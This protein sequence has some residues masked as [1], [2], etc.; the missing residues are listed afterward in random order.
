MSVSRNSNNN[1]GEQGRV[2]FALSSR[3]AGAFVI[4]LILL[5]SGGFVLVSSTPMTSA[6]AQEGNDTSQS[7]T[8]G[9]NTTASSPS[10]IELSPQPVYQEQIRDT[11]QIPINQTHLQITYSGSGTLNL[12]NTTEAIRTTS[13]GSGIASMIDNDF[14]GKE[15][16]TTE[17]GSESATARVYELVRFNM[18]EGNGRGITIATFHTN[19]T[20]MLAPLDGMI[21]TGITEL[22][23][24]GTG[25]V[26]LWEWQ[27]GIPYVRV[28]PTQEFTMNATV[29]P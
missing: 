14:A 6:L 26:T 11:G 18:Q 15:V 12:S 8:L 23:P 17:D 25:S 2:F 9:N 19:S 7:L 29:S 20:G 10:G 4:A 22:H 13:S 16:L 24:D 5:A 3:N 1:E 27:S 28:S 21:L